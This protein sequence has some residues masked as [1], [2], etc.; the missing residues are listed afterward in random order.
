MSIAIKYFH[1]HEHEVKLFCLQSKQLPHFLVASRFPTRRKSNFTS[2][3]QQSSEFHSHA[4][5]LN[6]SKRTSCAEKEREEEQEGVKPLIE[7]R[8]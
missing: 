6:M 8:K 2:K 7:I 1:T 5:F 3:D 4:S